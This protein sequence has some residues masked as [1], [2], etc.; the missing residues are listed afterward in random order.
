MADPNLGQLVTQAW[1]SIVKTQPEDN[2]FEDY[3]LLSK[4]KAGKGFKTIDGGR[5]I[6]VPLEYATNPTVEFVTQYAQL[7][8]TAS[9][10]F[11]TANYQWKTCAATVVQTELE[12]AINQGSGGKFDLLA[13]KLEN[14]KKSKESILNA[15]CFS[16]GTGTS[17]LE[18][19]GLQYLVATAPTTGTVGGINRANFAFWRNKTAAGTLSAAAFDNLRAAMRSV[20]NQ[21]S[22]GIAGDHPTF[23][24][25]TRTVFEGYE[26][27]LLG[28]ERFTSKESGEGAFK[29]EVLKFKG[30]EIAY[31]NDCL[32]AAAY[33]LNPKYIKLCVQKGR[34][35][36]MFSE[37]EPANQL[38][39]VFKTATI[40]NLIVTNPRM[41]GIVHT[42]T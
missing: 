1:E 36:K 42:I 7:S 8:T 14:L 35:M 15:A 29:N 13:A 22:N 25:T 28:N 32:A 41:L 26:G 34:W 19:G 23:A 30:A 37:V 5:E 20:Y 40:G 27:L 18:F 6:Q 38:L 10:V 33:F 3:W 2:I 11:D 9:D 17:G 39:R 4:L 24:V 16:D 31:D 21:C 12:D